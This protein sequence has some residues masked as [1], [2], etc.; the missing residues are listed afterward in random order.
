MKNSNTTNKYPLPK[1]KIWT[2]LPD[3]VQALEEGVTYKVYT[4]L[5]NQSGESDPIP[6]VLENTIGEIIWSRDAIGTYY[7]DCANLFTAN[8]TFTSVTN[9]DLT[10]LDFIVPNSTSQIYLQHVNRETGIDIDG[11]NDVPIEIRVYN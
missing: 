7:A 5:L 11:M 9:R 4:I 6:T 10:E 2:R 1:D 8:K 3:R